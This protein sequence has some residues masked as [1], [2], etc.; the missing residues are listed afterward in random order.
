MWI[1]PQ[2]IESAEVGI[3]GFEID[4][5]VADYSSVVPA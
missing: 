1:T 2:L 5:E 3:L 4:Q